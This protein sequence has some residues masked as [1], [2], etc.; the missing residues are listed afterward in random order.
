MALEFSDWVG[1]MI[2]S[3]EDA[4]IVDRFAGDALTGLQTRMCIANLLVP[5][6]STEK[7]VAD[8]LAAFSVDLN[9][10]EIGKRCVM[11]C[12]LQQLIGRNNVSAYT[13]TNG[14]Q[15]TAAW[16]KDLKKHIKYDTLRKED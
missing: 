5:Y 13:Q 4:S 10:N 7:S 12:S 3:I 8:W 9:D 15:E 11:E 1:R 14:D 2:N 6:T 16:L